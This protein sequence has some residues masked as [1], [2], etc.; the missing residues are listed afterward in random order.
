ML[1]VKAYSSH[2]IHMEEW[3]KPTTPRKGRGSVMD[4]KGVSSRQ[5]GGGTQDP[6]G[7]FYNQTKWD[8]ERGHLGL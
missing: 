3:F 6:R 1:L 2:S 7:W 5:Q 8:H 4:T